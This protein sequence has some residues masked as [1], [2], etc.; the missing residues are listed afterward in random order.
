MKYFMQREALEMIGCSGFG[1]KRTF[2]ETMPA[3]FLTLDNNTASLVASNT[4]AASHVRMA[5]ILKL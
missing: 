5:R 1:K 3:F 4:K 2:A